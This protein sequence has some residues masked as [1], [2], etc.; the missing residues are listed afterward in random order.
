MKPL[1]GL[2]LVSAAVPL[3]AASPYGDG[4]ASGNVRDYVEGKFLPERVMI[5]PV[6]SVNSLLLI[7]AQARLKPAA[8][9]PK[10][11]YTL[12]F[13]GSFRGDVESIEENPRFSV[14]AQPGQ[15]SPVLPS[16]TIQFLDAAGKALGRPQTLS[17]PCRA[18]HTYTDVFY[19]PPDA[20][21]L[22]LDVASGKG[23]N[24]ALRNLRLERTADEGALNVN[25]TFGLGPLNYSGWQRVSAGGQIVEID[26]KTVFDTKYGSRGMAFPLP[27]PGTYALSAKATGNGY[28]SCVK[29]DIFD[30]EGTKLMASVLRRYGRTNYFVPPKGAVSASLLVYSCLL[31]E[32]RLRRVGD[33]KAI[34]SLLSK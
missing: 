33:E 22:R 3:L 18:R 26:G 1:I 32:A 4:F 28:N 8:V 12:S 21:A 6:D 9:R 11:K 29:V 25:P 30:A 13:E 19:T 10:T 15:K 14:F 16:R 7:G 31:E 5:A 23:I 34:G 2:L 17:M 20:A 24:L 27:G